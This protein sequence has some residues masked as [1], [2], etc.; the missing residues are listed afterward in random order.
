MLAAGLFLGFVALIGL[1]VGM[2]ARH[3]AGAVAVLFGLLFIAPLVVDALPTPW[4]RR[5]EP[6][7]SSQLGAEMSALRHETLSPAA[8][9]AAAAARAGLT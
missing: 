3:S 6:Y 4:D 5:I 1:G 7:L 9:W 8:A 2:I